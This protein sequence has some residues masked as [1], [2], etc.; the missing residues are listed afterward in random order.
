MAAKIDFQREVRRTKPDYVV[1]VPK[2]SDGSTCDTG[3]EHFLVF[4]GPDG[5]LMAVWTQS[6]AEGEPN[7]RIVFARSDDEG[8]TW[9]APKIIAGPTPPAVG[10]LASW[11]FP[12]VSRAGRIYV[13]Y[14]KHVG[15]F[16]TFFHTTGL[17]AGVYSDDAGQRWSAPQVI[18]MPR[19][20][21]DNPDPQ[22]P[23]NWIVWQKPLRLSEGKYFVGFTRWVSQAVRHDPPT[24]SWTSAE[25]VVEFMRFENVDAHPEPKDLQ[26]SFFAQNERAIRVS[27]PDGPEVSVVQEPSIIKLPNGDLFTALRTCTGHP[28]YTTSTDAGRS[29]SAPAPI[30]YTDDGPAVEHPLSPCPIYDLGD[31]RYLFMYHNHDGHFGP[32]PK[33]DG[34][35]RPLWMS[36]G[37]Y[38]KEARQPIWFSPPK[39]FFDNDGVPLGT[40]GRTDISMYASVTVRDGRKILWYPDRKFFLVGRNLDEKVLS[41]MNIPG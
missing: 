32:W 38:R 34:I 13:L 23:A 35:R 14:S 11:G 10:N 9:T 5:S 33:E 29:W 12:L 27:H 18:P 21:Y 25:A 39:F 1:Y 17:M 4:D 24:E 26:I 22:Y 36:L 7:Q 41:D 40:C 6:T 31:G 16:D 8:K 28:Y 19:S 3:N 30:R 15:I 37:A 20:Q 2:S